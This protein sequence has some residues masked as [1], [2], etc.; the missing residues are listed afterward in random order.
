MG[1]EA[2]LLRV[3]FKK[4]VN[5][6]KLH[7]FL[8]KQGFK[9]ISKRG[10]KLSDYRDGCYEL[11]SDK[12]IT[13]ANILVP[14]EKITVIALSVRFS[15]ISPASV[16]DQTFDFFKE[17]NKEFELELQDTEIINHLW[18]ETTRIEDRKGRGR[19]PTPEEYEEQMK[20]VAIPID[21]EEFKKNKL[22]IRK[23]QSVLR[24]KPRQ[25]PL[26]CDDTL[27]NMNRN[28][29]LHLGH[30]EETTER[31]NGPWTIKETIPKYKN[32][33]IEVKE[34]QVIRPDGKPGIFGIVNMKSGISVLPIDDDG[35][36]YLTDEFHYAIEKD[37]IEVVSGAIDD[38]ETPIITAKREL[39]EELG[40]KANEWTELGVV[41]PFTTVIKSPAYL[42]LARKLTFT[43]SNQ[44]GTEN[45]KLVKV[46][47]K[48]AVK[49]VMESKITHSPS[50]V[51]ILKAKEFLEK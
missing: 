1:L 22:G 10:S 13:E 43:K 33:W 48:E 20:E 4:P 51:L 34:D 19:I 37:S 31:K 26:K 35:F 25:K 6:D 12:G 24:D 41:N 5:A 16:I 17:L 9:M 11:A 23:R 40:I 45:I 15:V 49:M 21:A 14:P 29:L 18:L 42:F 36:V 7:Y 39:E 46:K 50:C 28:Q 44:E 47:F 8:E 32:P 38:N 27:D 2:Y 30:L 3:K